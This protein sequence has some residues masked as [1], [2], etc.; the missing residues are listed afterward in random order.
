MARSTYFTHGTRNEQFLL[1][2]LVEEHLKMFGM[3][4]LY[5]PRKMVM[6]DGVFNEES[7]S[8]FDDAYIIEAYLENFDGFQGGGDLMTKFGIRQTDELTL[9]I[10]Q[11]R[12]SDL[13]SQFLLLDKGTT[14]EVGERPQ[15]GDLIYFPITSNFFEIKFVEH[16][17]PFYQLGKGYVYKL[18][19]ELFEYSNEQG[20]LFEGDEDLI[21]YGYTVK[22]YYLTTNGVTATG[23]P[24][25]DNGGIDQ[26]YITNNGSK[27][28]LSLIHI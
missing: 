21:D 26:I 15:E 1:Q 20:D 2:N 24:V 28:N 27:Y 16:E 19:C 17:E 12:F 5:C 22:H 11:Q 18:K 6:K 25:I 14:I 8:E 13:I 9:V 4:V 7:I 3:D 10:S 23:T